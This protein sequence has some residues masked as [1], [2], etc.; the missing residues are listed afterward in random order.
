MSRLSFTC[1]MWRNTWG[2]PAGRASPGRGVRGPALADFPCL[3][4]RARPGPFLPVPRVPAG[5]GGL[6]SGQGGSGHPPESWAAWPRTG[7]RGRG[8]WEPRA[9]GRRGMGGAAGSGCTQLASSFLA[10]GHKK[11]PGIHARGNIGLLS[12]LHFLFYKNLCCNRTHVFGIN[13]VTVCN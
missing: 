1:T 13:P 8:R 2:S 4:G 12:F 11:I 9:G 6:G 3:P 10:A 5:T 7:P